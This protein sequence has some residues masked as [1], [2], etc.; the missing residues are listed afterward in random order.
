MMLPKSLAPE[1]GAAFAVFWGMMW[2]TVTYVQD[3]G[4]Y[5]RDGAADY[6]CLAVH[7]RQQLID[8]HG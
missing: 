5:I 2:A 4:E 1:T 3:K 7:F 8:W 6:Y